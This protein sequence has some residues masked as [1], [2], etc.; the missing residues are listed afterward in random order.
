MGAV[1]ATRGMILYERSPETTLRELRKGAK[2]ELKP[3]GQHWF[4]VLWPK[5]FTQQG[6]EEFKYRDRTAA[7]MRRK[8]RYK[9]HQKPWVWSGKTKRQT[10]REARVSSTAKGLKVRLRAPRYIFYYNRHKELEKTSK[11]EVDQLAQQ[12]QEALTVR[13]NSAR[14]TE[15]VRV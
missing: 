13:L 15:R 7:Y 2:A 11:R 3:V 12:F 5:R 9:G 4:D 10:T 6:A 1:M 8:L 14:K